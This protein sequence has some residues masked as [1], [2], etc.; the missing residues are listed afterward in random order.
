MVLNATYAPI[1]IAGWK[2]AIKLVF[3]GKAS[4]VVAGEDRLNSRYQLPL[5]IRL[6]TYVPLPFNRLVLSRKN[7][8]L[9]DNHLCQYCG[10]SG[11]L[12]IDHVLPKSRGGVE[13]WENLV[14]SC[15]RCNNRKGDRLPT[16][17]GMELK[18]QPYR[19]ASA[20]YLLLTRQAEVP[21]SWD[22]YFFNSNN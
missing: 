15:M 22:R 5:V 4:V 3:K 12:T 14:T 19:P 21:S 9:R 13:T 1:N 6:A 7:L 20:L 18:R 8:Y 16:E 17:A 11:T 10:T 2:R